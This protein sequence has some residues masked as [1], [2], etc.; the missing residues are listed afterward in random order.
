MLGGDFL[1]RSDSCRVNA[2]R[3]KVVLYGGYAW[4]FMH[5]GE[6]VC[7]MI[8]CY[9]SVV[10]SAGKGH[11]KI[12]PSPELLAVWC[13]LHEGEQGFVTCQ[14]YKLLSSQLIFQ[15]VKAVHNR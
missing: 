13:S 5:S 6:S 7:D 3:N 12:L 9:S 11:E 15:K 1:C 10:N 8:V 14:E 2:V 4:F